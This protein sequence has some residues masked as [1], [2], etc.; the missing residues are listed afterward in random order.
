MFPKKFSVAKQFPAEVRRVISF[1]ERF[2]PSYPAREVELVQDR[3]MT[4]LQSRYMNRIEPL[5]GLIKL[6][7][8]SVTGIGRTGDTR[9]ENPHLAQEQIAS[10][11]AAQ[12]WGQLLSP[13]SARDRWMSFAIP[14]AYANFYLRGVYGVEDY[15][16]KMEA[17]KKR[18]EKP[19]TLLDSWKAAEAKKRPFSQSGS[20]PYSDVPKRARQDYGFYVFAEMLRLRIG[21]QAF[22]KALDTVAEQTRNKRVTTES[23]QGMLERVSKQDLSNFFDFWIH[24][25]LIPRLTVY[26]RLDK[27]EDGVDLFGCIES[28]LPF[29]IF[30]V[31]VRIKEKK[32][33]TDA[34]INMVHGYGSFTV[35]NVDSK[36]DVEIDPLGLL[37]SFARLHKRVNKATSCAKD[38][39][40]NN[41]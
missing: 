26:T 2:L 30:D 41:D 7:S 31:P 23:V 9:E 40:K 4:I 15:N 5:P 38:P 10:Q 33:S 35:P 11:L 18:I 1:M 39:M 20:T 12:Y 22:F 16:K 8:F 24:G 29:G 37:L 17:L 28:D 27:T 14:D 3:A 36:V 19:R 6:Q 21:N 34:I 25:G 13:N 32:G